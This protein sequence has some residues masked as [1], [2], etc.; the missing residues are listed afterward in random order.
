MAIYWQILLTYATRKMFWVLLLATVLF[1]LEIS[2]LLPNA[3]AQKIGGL[4]VLQ[5]IALALG[6]LVGIHVKHQFSNPRSTVMPHFRSTHLAV[7]ATIC[8]PCVALI[9]AF[10]AL[11]PEFTL[12]GMLAVTLFVIV[13]SLWMGCSPN[14]YATSAFFLSYFVP[15]T[16][17]GRGLFMEIV[18]GRE[19]LL[20]G[21]LL[22]G[23]VAGLVLFA[24]HLL[25]LTEDDLAYGIV[26]PTNPW[27][28]RAASQ[29]S[30]QRNMVQRGGWF[31]TALA[32]GA[33]SRLA[34]ASVRPATTFWQRVKLFQIGDTMPAHIG[35]NLA[36]IAV[37]EFGFLV[38]KGHMIQSELDLRM[39]LLVPLTLS[40]AIVCGPWFAWIQRWSRLGY[41]S[42]RPVTRRQWV[43]ENGA[44]MLLSSAIQNVT[45]IA[46][47]MVAVA[48][49]VPQ[50]AGSPVLFDAL[51]IAI[52]GQVLTF[53]MGAWL[54][55]FGSVLVVSACLGLTGGVTWLPWFTSSVHSGS[56]LSSGWIM[57]ISLVNVVVG[58]VFLKL[59]FR[60]WCR[61]DL[62]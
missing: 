27:D 41:E 17:F 44:G 54:T 6:M 49:F 40:G 53:G 61:M 48:C 3:L 15:M 4:A 12:G 51:L 24:G 19:P 7:A 47:Q 46:I 55:S 10:T 9:A 23:S 14:L 36:F 30:L 16:A 33:S 52:G 34:R 45:L 43:I 58:A 35:I 31:L 22:S 56:G 21:C 2:F 59:G 39:A 8:L 5:F 38:F 18:S 57:L 32:V 50:F 60:R 26:Y 11:I 62:P 37:F 42:L 13:V 25:N 20:V 28:L 1:S 29:R